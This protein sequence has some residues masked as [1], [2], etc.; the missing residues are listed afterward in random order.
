MGCDPLDILSVTAPTAGAVINCMILSDDEILKMFR[1]S[2][3]TEIETKRGP[4]ILRKAP[5]TPEAVAVWRVQKIHLS[6]AGITF[7]LKWKSDKDYELAWWKE[8]PREVIAKREQNAEMSRATD[9]DID[10]PAPPGRVYLPYQKAGVAFISDKEA[11]LLGDEMGLGKT[12]QAIGMINYVKEIHRVLIICPL[13]LKLNWYRELRSWMTKELSVGIAESK[14]FPSTDIVII[15]YDI[16]HKFKTR[17]EF[18][19]DLLIID[20]AHLIKNPKTRRAKNIVGYKPKRDEDPA[21][22]E[23][24]IPARRKLAMTGTPIVNRRPELYPIVHYLAP[25]IYSNW[26]WFTQK[27]TTDQ[28]QKS[29]RSSIMIRRLKKDVLLE[30]PAKR[31]QVIPMPPD[32]EATLFIQQEKMALDRINDRLIELE[33]AVELAKATD[34]ET[35]RKAVQSLRAGISVNFAEISKVRHETALAKLP[36]AKQFIEEMFS[37]V[38]KIIIL[39]YHRDVIESLEKS[40]EGV[41]CLK[42]YGG[43][44]P[45]ESQ[46]AVDLFQN[47]PNYH[48]II[49]QITVAVGMTLTAASTVVAVELDWVPGNMSQAEDRAHRIGQRDS[50]NV[51]HLVL[52]GSIDQNMAETLIEKQAHIDACLDTPGTT[53]EAQQPITPNSFRKIKVTRQEIQKEAEQFTPEKIDC[54]HGALKMLAGKCNHARSWDAAG[55]SKIDVAIG[56]SLADCLF[57]TPK[58]AV[59]GARLV[60]KYRRQLP[61]TILE[62]I[63]G[64]K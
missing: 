41:G 59:I 28:L 61:T 10:I 37:E 11:S 18:F 35:Y 27:A 26:F 24:G 8:V 62:Q 4:R 22:A 1:W 48:A 7:G 42:I 25:A 29:L 5:A 17:L 12:I 47:D 36:M 19:W 9:W 55:F 20:E 43:M 30:L 50:V 34:E 40:F 60:N 31:R 2:A 16:L 56:H 64:L 33:A 51:Y 21:L 38:D 58:Q 13:K 46:R 54:I 15:N 57:M 49:L 63:K 32:E 53:L 39:A 52:E 14:C 23:S 6:A 44:T 3:P 45:Q